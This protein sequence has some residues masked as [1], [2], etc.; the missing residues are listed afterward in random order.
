MSSGGRNEMKEIRG[1]GIKLQQAGPTTSRESRPCLNKK[2]KREGERK[3]Q[4]EGKWKGET[5]R[6]Y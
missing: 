5:K 4:K 6:D 1:M 2:G 3:G